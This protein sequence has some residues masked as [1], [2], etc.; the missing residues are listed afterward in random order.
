MFWLG[1]VLTIAVFAGYLVYRSQYRVPEGFI[2]VAGNEVIHGGGTF[3]RW[4]WDSKADPQL[5]KIAPQNHSIE[6]Q[7][8]SFLIGWEPDSTRFLDFVNTGA[9]EGVRT[10]IHELISKN[11]EII[12]RDVLATNEDGVLKNEPVGLL[13]AWAED[14]GVTWR[15]VHVPKRY[16]G[17][18]FLSRN[19]RDTL[20]QFTTRAQTLVEVQVERKRFFD[21]WGEFLAKADEAAGNGDHPEKSL[22]QQARGMFDAAE[23]AAK[24]ADRLG[25]RVP[26]DVP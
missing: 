2:L 16:V 11:A 7:I 18:D 1:A 4:P 6:T 26:K 9:D 25:D 5:W 12:Q 8:G 15:N 21:Q 14:L 19:L 13:K 22:V 23:Q 24:S 3:E 20:A 10:K 17:A